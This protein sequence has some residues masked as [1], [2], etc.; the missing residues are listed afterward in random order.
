MRKKIEGGGTES[1]EG[2]NKGRRERRLK[3]GE[4][5]LIGGG[6]LDIEYEET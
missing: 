2:K 5:R 3:G 1:G 4:K 6:L